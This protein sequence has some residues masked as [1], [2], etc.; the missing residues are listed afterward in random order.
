[1][2]CVKQNNPEFDESEKSQNIN[3]LSFQRNPLF[4]NSKEHLISAV[5]PDLIRHPVT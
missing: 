5:M 4:H 3:P 1:M 2:G